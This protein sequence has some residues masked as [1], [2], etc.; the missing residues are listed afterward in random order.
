M[1][2]IFKQFLI[3]SFGRESVA[4]VEARRNIGKKKKSRTKQATSS[5]SGS[6]SGDG[7][8]KGNGGDYLELKSKNK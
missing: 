5:M 4:D 7:Q 2:L 8:R 3:E 6:G 1:N